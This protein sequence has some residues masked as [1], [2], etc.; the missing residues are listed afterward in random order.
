MLYLK[1]DMRLRILRIFTLGLL[2]SI[3]SSC[4]YRQNF[5]SVRWK[6]KGVDWWMTDFREKMVDDLIQSDTLIGMNRT[7]VTDLLGEPDS[8]KIRELVYLIREIYTSDIDPDYIS[9]LHIVFNNAG[10]VIELKI[11]K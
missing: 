10:N 8:K 7:E 5:D 3:I 1:R 9:N 11:E 2:V 4:D 6:Q